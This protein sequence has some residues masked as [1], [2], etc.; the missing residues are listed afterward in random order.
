MLRWFG[1]LDGNP[2][3]WKMAKAVITGGEEKCEESIGQ[4][5]EPRTTG[6]ISSTRIYGR[7]P[8]R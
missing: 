6:I 2:V 7:V 5:S 8:T 1:A 3:R 4:G